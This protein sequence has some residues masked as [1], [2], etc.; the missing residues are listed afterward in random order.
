[1]K[2]KIK[3]L[4]FLLFMLAGSM[5]N[6][7]HAQQKYLSELG[8]SYYENHGVTNHIEDT[9][10]QLESDGY[11]CLRMDLNHGAGGASHAVG[12]KYTT[13]IYKAIKDIK[14][15]IGYDFF[16][17]KTTSFYY[18][19]DEHMFNGR[20]YVGTKATDSRSKYYSDLNK[21]A[22][23]ADL[24]LYYTT[25]DDPNYPVEGVTE[26][27]AVCPET[28]LTSMGEWE[29]VGG[30]DGTN[31]YDLVDANLGT[32][33][34][35]TYVYLGFKTRKRAL[36]LN[37]S[38]QTSWDNLNTNINNS[39]NETV[40]LTVGITTAKGA[41]N[42]Y[43]INTWN[44][45]NE[46][47]KVL[48]L[49]G[50]SNNLPIYGQL[51]EPLI[52]IQN[53]TVKMD[54]MDIVNYGSGAT[55]HQEGGK[56]ILNS[57]RISTPST[58]PLVVD[59]GEIAL[60]ATEIGYPDD[61]PTLGCIGLTV[62]HGATMS[63]DP[64]NGKP[65]FY[66]ITTDAATLGTIMPDDYT[67]ADYETGE[68]LTREEM[69]SQSITERWLTLAPCP[70]EMPLDAFADGDYKCCRCGTTMHFHINHAPATAEGTTCATCGETIVSK[71]NIAAG[72]FYYTQC[73]KLFDAVE[74][75][76]RTSSRSDISTIITLYGDCT[77]PDGVSLNYNTP[78]TGL[79]TFAPL[80]EDAKVTI[81]GNVSAPL[82][83]VNNAKAVFG[84]VSVSN[85][86]SQGAALLIGSTGELQYTN[87]ILSCAN[88]DAALRID[89]GGKALLEE[90][91]LTSTNIGS[92]KLRDIMPYGEEHLVGQAVYTKNQG[93]L[94]H[95]D[96]QYSGHLPYHLYIQACDGHEFV[97]QGYEGDISAIRCK[98]CG[99]I[100]DFDG[101]FALLTYC[102]DE[103]G[104]TTDKI[105]GFGKSE[106]EKVNRSSTPA[107]LVMLANMTIDG[108]TG[109]IT[110]GHELTITHAETV[111]DGELTLRVHTTGYENDDW[112]DN[113]IEVRD[114][115]TLN[116]KGVNVSYDYH[117]AIYN[118]GT[119]NLYSGTITASQ[120]VYCFDG[121][122][123][124]YGGSVVGLQTS[125]N[126][127]S[128]SPQDLG[129][130]FI[131]NYSVF[132][133]YGGTIR[134]ETARTDQTSL[135]SLEIL[136]NSSTVNL[137]GGTLEK[138]FYSH[139]GATLKE[140]LTKYASAKVDGVTCEDPSSVGNT[141]S[142]IVI[143]CKHNWSEWSVVSQTYNESDNTFVTNN[144]RTC[145]VCHKEESQESE[146]LTAVATKRTIDGI[147]YLSAHDFESPMTLNENSSLTL[148]QDIS[149]G[150][151]IN[152]GE[153]V[154]V[155]VIGN[156]TLTAAKDNSIFNNNGVL[157]LNNVK[158]N[159]PSAVASIVNNGE[160]TL[161]NMN[162]NDTYS[163][164]TKNDKINCFNVTYT[165]NSIQHKWGTIAVP[166]AVAVSA[167]QPY[168]LYT[169]SQLN[170]NEL[171][172]T[173]VTGTL[174][175]GTPALIRMKDAALNGE[176]T[177]DL[178]IKSSLAGRVDV[179]PGLSADGITYIG[180]Y[181]TA[182]VAAGAGYLFNG[183]K[184]VKTTAATTVS[185]YRAYLAGA[186]D[187][188]SVITLPGN[189]LV[190]DVNEDG[191][192]TITDITL[193]IK[194]LNAGTSVEDLPAADLDG[195][196]V[197]NLDDLEA[198]HAKILNLQ[199]VV[200]E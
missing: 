100:E 23:G 159:T 156:Y 96:D 27:T 120:P 126:N 165:R 191:S 160:L 197:I 98:W 163:I 158:I 2:T 41:L 52:N 6:V 89:E 44:Y 93:N 177:Y 109:A 35:D 4:M 16:P 80:N 73:D 15:F 146:A 145:S 57:G 127:N 13:D 140:F 5:C 171:T 31:V 9:Y 55:M 142:C 155:F 26:L 198:L 61:I 92:L 148:L 86:N 130:L 169:L 138:G 12:Y 69:L 151:P 40:D 97:R 74:R 75:N 183:N 49:K 179:V 71:M 94:V 125:T 194:A 168:E 36:F 117:W 59:G 161:F 39:A 131:Q 174:K 173:K 200:G 124:M 187:G 162:L 21:G 137:Y 51:D 152:I 144:T 87:G 195:E 20:K 182:E 19:P 1:M 133:M 10:D 178:S 157:S 79:I 113:S 102:S 119:L 180:T 33:K 132:N 123:N 175:A 78:S 29:E 67:L 184:F 11:T 149:I 118:E 53:G 60:G 46:T 22:G 166:F 47:T 193:L 153:E 176:G 34:H 104:L 43:F 18:L 7:V 199:P 58:Q 62:N 121:T 134:T 111:E 82:I 28:E 115:A 66:G 192:I 135:R 50:N 185:P 154:S 196:G 24:Y 143:E 114:G 188:I 122:F 64:A 72:E 85:T 48:A 129:A 81:T 103:K 105:S 32:T 112:D 30:W 70:H 25:E 141:Y 77:V 95:L 38:A 63:Y 116:I 181:C 186:I 110:K 167:D 90:C 65:R 3:L 54:G 99:Y 76:V 106:F 107:T 139:N 14:I 136:N 68:V 8:I 17:F 42:S 190:G 150:G 56:L 37:G 164:D 147:T 83:S 45:N 172:L 128:S 88:N 91:E 189:I 170:G 108:S 84:N 101:Y